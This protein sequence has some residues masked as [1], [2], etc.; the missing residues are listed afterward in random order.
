M[1]NLKNLLNDFDVQGPGI[2]GL[3]EHIH[4]LMYNNIE[5]SHEEKIKIIEQSILDTPRFCEELRIN[6]FK[7]TENDRK[8]VRDIVYSRL[9]EEGIIQN[10]YSEQLRR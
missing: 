1:V 3:K 9:R 10:N 5:G 2:I 7:P 6:C 4:P 8:K